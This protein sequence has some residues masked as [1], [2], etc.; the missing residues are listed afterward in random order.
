MC[1]IDK[2]SRLDFLKSSHDDHNDLLEF[3]SKIDQS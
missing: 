2:I 3:V 1:E